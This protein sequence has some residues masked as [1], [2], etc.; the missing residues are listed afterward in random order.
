MLLLVVGN[1]W[2]K[3]TEGN[4]VIFAEVYLNTGNAACVRESYEAFGDFKLIFKNSSVLNA[5]YNRLTY[6]LSIVQFI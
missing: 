2:S 1:T 4:S 3:Y 6:H 5:S